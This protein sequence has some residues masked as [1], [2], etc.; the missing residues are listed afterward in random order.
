M[1]TNIL[2]I[3]ESVFSHYMTRH[4]LSTI[5]DKSLFYTLSCI[6]KNTL[7][8]IKNCLLSLYTFLYNEE[9]NICLIHRFV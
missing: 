4:D 6:I 7:S 1:T 3:Y 5:I 8:C 2:L 9:I